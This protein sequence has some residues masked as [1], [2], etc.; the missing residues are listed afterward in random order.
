MVVWL[1]VVACVAYFICVSTVVGGA[2]RHVF[3]FFLFL[4]TRPCKHCVFHL[5]CIIWCIAY[6]RAFKCACR[7]NN[8]AVESMPAVQRDDDELTS[9]SDYD[10]DEVRLY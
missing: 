5:L 4:N 3:A 2:G 7:K 8:R 1:H 6:T 10:S 9:S